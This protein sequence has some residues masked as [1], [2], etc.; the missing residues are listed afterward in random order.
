MKKHSDTILLERRLRISSARENVHRAQEFLESIRKPA[1]IP[2]GLFGKLVV[3]LTEAV[4]NGIIHGN[5]ENPRRFVAVRFVLYQDRIVCTVRDQGKG[6]EPD[7]LPDPCAD[8]NLMKDGGRGVHIIKSIMHE[9][10]FSRTKS[11]MILKFI[12]R[13]RN[14]RT[15][16]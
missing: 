7:S 14:R 6:F 13:L 10:T 4:N 11:G 3:A 5:K 1:R 8:E 2:K 12:A 16:R 15:K 9:T